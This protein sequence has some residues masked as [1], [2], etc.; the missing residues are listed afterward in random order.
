M[1]KHRF[2][3]P[4]ILMALVGCGSQESA[5]NTQVN[6][7]NFSYT[8][9][10]VRVDAGDDFV[11]LGNQQPRFALSSDKKL[12]YNFD[13][14]TSKLE[15]IDLDRLTL[16]EAITIEKDGPTGIGFNYWSVFNVSNQGDLF[17]GEGKYIQ[18]L[19]AEQDQLTKYFFHS[20][21]LKGDTLS[22]DEK[23]NLQGEVSADGKFYFGTYGKQGDWDS[24]TG[25]A[26]VNLQTKELQKIPLKI[27]EEFKQFNLYLQAAN[28][29]ITSAAEEQVYVMRNGNQL[30]ISSSAIN[31]LYLYNLEKGTTEK[32]TFHS[33]LTPDSKKTDY[34]NHSESRDE[35]SSLQLEKMKDV[36]FGMFLFDD[37]N[38]IY[39]RYTVQL[40]RISE[41]QPIFNSY[42]T[43]FDEE[44][45]Q[46]HEE[47]M[48]YPISLSYSFFIEG[49][50]YYYINLEDELGF[51]RIKPTYE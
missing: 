1:T 8:I 25:L 49:S 21:S 32:K 11:H 18:R 33:S 3:F 26:I 2:L 20:D 30:L 19:N 31:E 37:H 44:L 16:K 23:I 4:I 36:N 10:T 6:A 17:L 43:I 48:D 7:I 51:V 22:K 39:W 38:N 47:K 50:L 9:D 29:N 35:F 41:N 13:L 12:L 5:E 27:Y 46:I 40:D 24:E 45:N 42:L 14:N 34:K 15:I 28:G